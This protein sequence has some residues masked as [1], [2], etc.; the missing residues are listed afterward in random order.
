MEIVMSNKTD[1]WMP[2]FIGDYLSATSRLTTQQHGAYFLLLMDY[3]K[4]G[5]P[6]DDDEVLAQITKMT[7]DAWS[8]ARRI[9]L[10]YF[11]IE[12]GH[13]VQKRI[14]KELIDSKTRK[15]TAVAKAKAG[16][17]ARWK[18]E[19]DAS[20]I[21]QA[22]PDTMLDPMLENASSPS[23]SPSSLSLP[24]TSN[25]TTKNIYSA[26]FEEFWLDYPKREGKSAAFKEWKRIAPDKE[27]Q[28]KITEGLLDY[29]KSRKVK[30]GFI[31]DC[32]NWLKGKHWEDEMLNVEIVQKT[33]ESPWQK[34]DRLRMQELA[35][36]VA[37]RAHD[38]EMKTID[39]AFDSY[40]R[41]QRIQHDITN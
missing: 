19:I 1:I 6:P 39:E 36:G 40:K 38:D 9:L 10:A 26:D 22:I 17:S 31:K 24:L 4:N 16:A 12:N 8:N 34:A 37:T 35:P 5:R 33:Y 15:E 3:W 11:Q 29:R 20:S 18:K 27:L 41:P 7:P 14:E 2:I 25:K 32:V 30:E 23:P 21:A 13:W 28:E